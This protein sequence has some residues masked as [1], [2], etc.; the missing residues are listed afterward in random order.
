MNN[1]TL[2][3]LEDGRLLLQFNG[4]HMWLNTPN[5]SKTFHGDLARE[6]LSDYMAWLR[7]NVERLEWIENRKI[8]VK[9]LKDDGVVIDL[10]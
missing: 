1:Y 9:E 4:K 7:N 10:T 5:Y 2:K 8:E 3:N 6:V